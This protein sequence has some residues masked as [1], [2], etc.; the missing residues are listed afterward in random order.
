MSDSIHHLRL[1]NGDEII[2]DVVAINEQHIVVNNPMYV[3]EQV[4][5]DGKAV[6]VL[7]KYIPFCSTDYCEFRR[8]HILTTVPL[9]TSMSKY[10]YNS[11]F[12]TESHEN[13]MIYEIEKANALMEQIIFDKTSSAT[14]QGNQSVN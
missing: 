5:S 12:F 8:D 2:A 14:H 9:N 4:N 1:V 3:N 11:L 13:K 6:V 7:T 10:Y